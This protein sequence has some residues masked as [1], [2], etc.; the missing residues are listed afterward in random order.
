V[1]RSR[2]IV[3]LALPEVR[4]AL[5]QIQNAVPASRRAVLSNAADVLW[6]QPVGSNATASRS[7]AADLCLMA[8]IAAPRSRWSLGVDIAHD[9]GVQD[10]SDHE[11][12]RLRRLIPEDGLV[13]AASAN[14]AALFAAWTELEARKA[15][16]SGLTT[17][18]FEVISRTSAAHVVPLEKLLLSDLNL[19]RGR[20]YY[21]TLALLP[22][23][24][25]PPEWRSANWGHECAPI[26]RRQHPFWM[27]PS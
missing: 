3:G 15:L 10:V 23:G 13:R 16:R 21:A 12:S 2:S 20:T 24:N 4:L 6:K 1:L 14:R 27:R 9:G 7:Y 17:K 8:W 11:C 26:R 19:D 18:F 25:F 22:C 5:L